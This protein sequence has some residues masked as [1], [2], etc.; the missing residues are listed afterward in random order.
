MKLQ[1]KE[2]CGQRRKGEMDVGSSLLADGE[3]AE[4]GAPRKHPLDEPSVP[5][6]PLAALNPAPGD[7][8]LDPLAVELQTAAA[9]SQR[10]RRCRG[11]Q[12]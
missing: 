12:R 2:G 10:S 3:A 5:S 1:T 8:V 11:R 9:I 7:A 4:L 6:Q